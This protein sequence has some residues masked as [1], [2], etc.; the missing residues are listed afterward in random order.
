MGGFLLGYGL[1]RRRAALR[2]AGLVG[3]LGGFSCGQVVLL[4]MLVAAVARR[5]PTG[6]ALAF[7]FLHS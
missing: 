5:F 4:L 7:E 2:A 1:G 3:L 6:R